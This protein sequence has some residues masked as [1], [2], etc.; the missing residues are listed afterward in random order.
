MSNADRTTHSST[1][2]FYV[3]AW[4]WHFYAGIAVLPFVLILAASGLAMLVSSP[5]ERLMHGEL[6]EVM[7]QGVWLPAA[8]QMEVVAAAYPHADVATFAPPRSASASA[9][10]SIV[11]HHAGAPAGGH[12]DSPV[13]TVFVNPYTGELLGA[14]DPNATPYAWAKRLHGTLL[15]GT[16]GDYLIEIAAGFAVLLVVS[17][18]YLWWP[19]DGRRV[20]EALLPRLEVA[21]RRRWRDVHAS[22]GV[23]LAPLL[24]FLLVSGLAWTPFWGGELV[25][26]WS[27][28]P[29]ETFVPDSSATHASLDHGA[30]RTVPW[31]VEQTPLPV[32]GSSNA[33]GIVARGAITLDDVIGYAHGLGLTSFRVHLPNPDRQVWTIAATTIGGDTTDLSGDRIVHLDAATGNVLADLAFADYSAFGKLMAAGIP[34]HQGDTGFLNVGVNVTAAVGVIG[35][36]LAAVLAWWRRRPA[37]ALRLVPPP[38]PQDPR[39]W[40]AAVTLMLLLSLALPLVAATIAVVLALDLL[41]LSRVRALRVLFE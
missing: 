19:R 8:R 25:Q 41:V 21:G 14:L 38:L 33:P 12:G 40:P 10:V 28:L 37:R 3:A 23:W 5:V 6:L 27:S 18:V 16:F 17:G 31:A 1:R 9:A 20:R 4:R 2:R 24:L 36:G 26:A 39:A 13:M 34:L 29:S 30:H 35:L 7:P 22:L 15:L 11:P 32:A